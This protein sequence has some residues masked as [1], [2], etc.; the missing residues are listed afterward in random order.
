MAQ[1]C[2]D[3]SCRRQRVYGKMYQLMN[4]YDPVTGQFA[5][6]NIAKTQREYLKS[7]EMRNT[8]WFD[9]LFQ[10]QYYA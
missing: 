8:D 3:V 2:R 1:L 7:A 9:E 6:M 10:Y 5:L 4:T